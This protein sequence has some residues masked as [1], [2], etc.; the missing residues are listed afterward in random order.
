MANEME[1]ESE[2]QWMTENLA[3]FVE[4]T[5][6]RIETRLSD[7]TSYL[8]QRRLNGVW[9]YSRVIHE[10]GSRAVVSN[11]FCSESRVVLNFGSQDYLGLSKHPEV[12]TSVVSACEQFGVHSAGSA[13]LAGRT[14]GMFELEHTIAGLLGKESC[15]IYPTGWAAGFGVL[16]GLVRP[17]DTIVM[18]RLAHNCLAEGAKHATSKLSRFRHNDLSRYEHTVRMAREENRQSGLFVIVESLYSMDSDSPDLQ[19]FV[20]IAKRYDGIVILDVAHD[21]GAMGNHGLGLLDQTPREYWPDVIMGSFSKSF[22]SNGGFVA[23]SSQVV[24]YLRCY[25]PSFTFS[26]ALSPIQVASVLTCMRLVFSKTG[27]AFRSQLL[28]N[29]VHLRDRMREEG[30]RVGGTPSP[31]V[32]V[33]VG[34]ELDARLIAKYLESEG[35]L[36]NLVE[37]PAV[38][39]GEARFRF[40]VMRTHAEEEIEVAARIMSR[41]RVRI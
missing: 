10:G 14:K 7:W 24:D 37:Y 35:L 25:S 23:S 39:L 40:Q 3:A 12:I 29:I 41:T 22:A 5:G 27:D 13:I 19:S 36:A 38:P 8:S 31:I 15:L 17:N 32:P 28:K 18:D 2:F 20:E 34:S 11:E 6:N 9:P 26:N 4:Q 1:L 33:F 30:F 16:V 21:F